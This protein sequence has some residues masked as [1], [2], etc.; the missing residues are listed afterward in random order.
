VAG[1]RRAHLLRTAQLQGLPT[2][3]GLYLPEELLNAE[4]VFTA[5]VASLRSIWQIGLMTYAIEPHPL[6]TKLLS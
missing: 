1:V 5:N 4:A 2:A 6:Y 3:E